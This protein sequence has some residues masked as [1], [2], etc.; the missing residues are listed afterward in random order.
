MQAPKT[1]RK[2]KLVKDL[3]YKIALTRIPLVG[4][5]TAKI[6]VS[7]CGGV[8][9]V[10]EATEKELNKIPGIGEQVAKQVRREEP[11]VEAEQEL[12]FVEKNGLRVLF[13][14]DAGYPRRLRSL[15]DA[16]ILLYF[17]GNCEL[18]QRRVL[19]VVGTRSPSPQ[20]VGICEELIKGLAPYQPLIVSGLAYGIDVSAHRA[21][22]NEGLETVAVLG[23]GLHQIYP[24]QHKSIAMKMIGQ[25]GLLTEFTSRE[26]PLKDHFPMRNR[27]VAGLC[28]AIIV[29]ETGLR[30][31]SIITAKQ[32]NGYGRDVFAV[33]GR[34]K[35]KN[36]QGCNMMIKKSWAHL[37]E[38]ADD[39][40]RILGWSLQEA[41]TGNGQQKLFEELTG[42]ERKVIDLIHEAEEI[43]IDQ[44]SYR[45]G[46]GAAELASLLLG[47]EFKGLVRS[48]PGKRY[49]L[50]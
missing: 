30:G 32:A 25:G 31:G 24:A 37:L 19:G 42:S 18:N 35:D 22:L 29:I 5:V 45:S 38:S 27:I 46:I 48:L 13:Y 40:A 12:A 16:P 47:L 20:G 8:R 39:V 7:Y 10:F 50:T 14:L 6:L 4:A 1:M 15:A 49:V 17:K 36:A 23:H 2:T 44:L 11:L 26:D 33:P 28:D 34:V 21:S 9:E 3:L 43:G 41:T